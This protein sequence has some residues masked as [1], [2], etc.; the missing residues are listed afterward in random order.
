MTLNILLLW[1]KEKNQ[2]LSWWW[3]C[4]S[5][6]LSQAA[7]VPVLQW[8]AWE[9]QQLQILMGQ[10]QSFLGKVMYLH[11][12]SWKFGFYH[13]C[14]LFQL[15]LVLR[16]C[17]DSRSYL[18]LSFVPGVRVALALA[19]WCCSQHRSGWAVSAWAVCWAKK[20]SRSQVGSHSQVMPVSE[21]VQCMEVWLFRAAW[22]KH[23]V[24]NVSLVKRVHQ[25]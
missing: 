5:F 9:P 4:S 12:P 13:S 14:G 1:A 19:Q 15:I 10:L 6:L 2:L 21:N 17:K 11:L 16:S 20:L 7:G 23:T 22:L 18:L 24:L 8:E 25:T 3:E